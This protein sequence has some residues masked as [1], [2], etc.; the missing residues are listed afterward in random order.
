M[1]RRGWLLAWVLLAVAACSGGGGGDGSRATPRR[2]AA[3][4][5]SIAPVTTSTSTSSRPAPSSSTSTAR[6]APTVAAVAPSTTPS[7]RP[8]CP[9]FPADNPWNQDVSARPLSA[10]SGAWVASVGLTTG[11]HPDFGTVYEGA[12]IGIPYVEVP[13]GQARVP[14]RFEYADESDPGPYPIPADAPVEG[15]AG[16]TGDRHV[17]AL[18]R[19]E[20][21]LWEL[22]DAHPVNGGQSW[23][24]GSGATWDL[25]SNALRPAGWTSADAAGLPIFPGL[26]RYDEVAAGHIDH[27]L[28]FTASRTQRGY[29]TPATHFASSITDA[30]VAP[31]GARFRLQSSFDCT[32]LR[33]QAR[34]VCVALQRYGM[35]LADNGSNW[36]V[37]GSPDARW[38]DDELHD[39]GRVP[40]SAFE[41]VE[42]GAVRHER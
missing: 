39:L 14:V 13:P 29:I 27:A 11:L 35:L 25:R 12:P 9:I 31:M 34:V 42:T 17:L 23:T 19:S 24:A 20:C 7:P 21:R 6:P 10:R 40:G 37:S 5:T 8:S 3:A 15:G 4:T 2:A 1:K 22:F 38:S 28:R 18:D 26:V 41:V 32:R 16:S 33:P 36:Y 30:D